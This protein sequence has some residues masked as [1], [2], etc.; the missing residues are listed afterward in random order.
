MAAGIPR[1]AV[2][3]AAAAISLDAACARADEGGVSFWA[4]GQMGS[5][6]AV[7]GEP[8]F[9]VPVVYLHFSAGSEA[10]KA[11]VT[12]GRLV[13]DLDATGDLVFF[14]PT[15]TFKEPVAG[16][17]AAISLGFAVGQA[18]V[19][20]SEAFVNAL[21]N[22]V[23]ASRTDKV[24]GGSDLY[25]LGTL[26]WHDGANNWLA[27]GTG[28]VPVGAYQLHRLAN[29]G[30]NHYSLDAG[31]GYTY[32]DPNKGHEFSI[33]GGLTYNFENKDTHY[34]NGIDGHI[35]WAASQFLSEQTHVGIVGYLYNQL[36]GD[37][38]SGAVLGDYKSRVYSI[39]P[40]VGYFFPVGKAKGY[41]NLR[42]YWEF[43]EQ[44]RAAGWNTWLTLSLPL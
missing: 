25:Y 17:Q 26:K 36:T 28:N 11:F 20:A 13:F 9:E 30:I 35:D 2:L 27:Y 6:S 1:V 40:Q 34:Q 44:N 37:S 31:G 42:A 12:G 8:G 24:T 22:T 15:Y 19:T 18:R 38:G 3:A 33:V 14:F 29:I 5:F 41:V 16:A 32:L 23:N 10:S 4:P 21:G 39:G 43:G 7:P